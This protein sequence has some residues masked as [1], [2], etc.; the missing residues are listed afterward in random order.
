VLFDGTAVGVVVRRLEA[1]RGGDDVKGMG[2]DGSMLL[3]LVLL[4]A[5]QLFL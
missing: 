3:F 2:F 1:L 4:R 5:L